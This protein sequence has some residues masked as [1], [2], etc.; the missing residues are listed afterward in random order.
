MT[1]ASHTRSGAPVIVV[2]GNIAGLGTAIALR[3]LGLHPIVLERMP[4]QPP[5]RGGLHIWTNGA[6][7][8]NWL[9]VGERVRNAGEAMEILRFRRWDGKNLVDAPVG[10]IGRGTGSEAFFVPRVDVPRSLLE[11][12]DGIDIRWGAAVAAI[13]QDAAGVTARLEDGDEVRGS[14]LVGADGIGSGVRRMLLGDV[15]LRYAG[16][17][18][19]GAV[20]EFS[21]EKFP[22]GEFWTLFGPG[23][24]AGLAHIGGGRIYWAASIPRPQ[25]QMDPPTVDEL[26][27]LY[28]GWAE[29]LEEVLAATPPEAMV[30]APIRELTKL[31]RWSDGRIALV[32]DAAH[33]M[34]PC[35]GRGASEALEDAI[36]LAGTLAALPSLNGSSSVEKALQGWSEKRKPRVGLVQKRSRQIGTL[37]L[38]R[39]TQAGRVRDTYLRMIGP[40]LIRQ[41]RID[42]REALG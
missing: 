3:R 35:A 8:L 39:S 25:G 14:V 17:Q 1:A 29:P 32:G 18:D 38:W 23:L 19:W 16:Y 28:K 20:F 9:G 22:P 33:A 37:G 5:V 13:E 42:F 26:L 7:A 27:R 36:T 11:A 40:L 10:E 6:K 4:S 41:M 2:G 31:D 21:H 24:R 12:S 34:Q 15:G 30:G